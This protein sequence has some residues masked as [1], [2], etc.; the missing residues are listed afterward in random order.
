MWSS[1]FDLGLKVSY[2]ENLLYLIPL[3][4]LQVK[5]KFT[6]TYFNLG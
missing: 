5:M 4:L 1:M 2:K 3:C 6:L